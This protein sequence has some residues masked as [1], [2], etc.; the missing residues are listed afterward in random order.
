MVTDGAR[1]PVGQEVG[2]IAVGYGDVVT[3]DR[4]HTGV[5]GGLK[6]LVLVRETV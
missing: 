5:D 3:S 4:G 2:K 6:K 1:P